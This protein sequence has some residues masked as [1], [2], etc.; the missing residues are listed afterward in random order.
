[1]IKDKQK[2]AFIE[3]LKKTPI[4]QFACE[5]TGISRA[6]YYRMRN[7]SP[8][9]AKAVDDAL[10]EGILLVNDLS[11]SQLISLIKERKFQAISLWLSHNHKRYAPKLELSG[12]V[13]QDPET[14]SPE[15][16]AVIRA[17][18]KMDAKRKKNYDPSKKSNKEG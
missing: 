16:K 10:A 9:F 4:L 17:A 7:Q 1:M 14:L 5:R 8:E 3:H 18:L 12:R 6:T 15:Q 11:E 2:L 13:T